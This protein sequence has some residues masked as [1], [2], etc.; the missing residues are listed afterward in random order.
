MGYCPFRETNSN[1]EMTR[2]KRTL[3]NKQELKSTYQLVL[4]SDYKL[5]SSIPFKQN[6]SMNLEE[7]SLD[8][9]HTMKAKVIQNN[10]ILRDNFDSSQYMDY[11]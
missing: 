3:I 4:L 10:S 1:V 9:S 5:K 6:I 8:D 2:S 7:I 11:N